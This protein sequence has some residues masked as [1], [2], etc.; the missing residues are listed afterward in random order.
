MFKSNI[1]AY[2]SSDTPFDRHDKIWLLNGY[3]RLWDLAVSWLQKTFPAPKETTTQI[4]V[5]VI[6]A[7]GTLF[8]QGRC[9]DQDLQLVHI[10]L[11][12]LGDLLATDDLSYFPVIQLELSQLINRVVDMLR[13]TARRASITDKSILLNNA[14]TE[15]LAFFQSLEPRLQVTEHE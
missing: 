9:T 1:H 15:R 12:K 7:A 5:R 13:C 2:T 4:V 11:Q 6:A 3:Q 14:M 8:T 10:V